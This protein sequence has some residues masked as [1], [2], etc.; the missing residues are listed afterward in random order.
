MNL[1]F[2]HILSDIKSTVTVKEDV[3]MSLHTTMRVGG[4]ARYFAECESADDVKNVLFA[5]KEAEVDVMVIGNGS[6]LLFSD[7]G[8]DGVILHLGSGFADIQINGNEMRCG[9]GALMS[10]AAR[11]ALNAGLTGFE[12]LSG[13]PGTIGGGVYMNAGAYGGEISQVLT[14]VT[15]LEDGAIRTYSA[16]EMKLGYRHSLAMEKKMILLEAVFTLQKGEH[17]TILAAMNDY[18]QRRRDKQPLEYPSAG[19]FFKRPEGHFA[20]AL[21]EGCGLKGYRVGGAQVSEKH[22]GFLI[23]RGGAT[24]SDIL[25][26]M[27][28]VQQ[29]VK[30][31]TG[32]TLEPEVRIIGGEK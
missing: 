31:E 30:Q 5:A 23:N 8:F 15:V 11:A 20:G 27:R 26:L 32:V 28:Y 25:D 6:N 24:A 2:I 19:S 9:A 10:A 21:I 3:P 17:D 13:I 12:A 29:T 7:D 18:N 4:R 14:G 1:E 22:A 16:A